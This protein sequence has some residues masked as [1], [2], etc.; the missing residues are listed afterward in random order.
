MIARV[1]N[2]AGGEELHDGYQHYWEVKMNRPVYG[3]NVMVGL[4]TK[5]G[6]LRI[7]IVEFHRLSRITNI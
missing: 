4:A 3:T 1:F 6:G 2:G 7:D 5:G